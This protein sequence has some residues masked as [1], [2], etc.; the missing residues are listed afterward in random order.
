MDKKAM[1]K[2][3]YGLYLVTTYANGIDN[4]CIVNSVTQVTSDPQRIQV[5]L[6]KTDLTC[7]LIKQSKKLNLSIFDETVPFEYFQLFGM[8]S[9]KTENKFAMFK[10]VERSKNGI[11]Y[12]TLHTNALICANVIQQLDLDT[13]IM[14]IC[15]VEDMMVL[16]SNPSV[17]YA[18][19]QQNIKPVTKINTTNSEK[20]VCSICGYVYDNAVE[21]IPFEELP[22]TWVCPLCNHPKSV[23][24][25]AGNGK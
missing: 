15:E 23:F 25:K 5:T 10:D 14:F 4:G 16:N 11:Y 3:G 7:D 6:Q 19:Y 8:K 18:Y 9:G 20:W 2:I 24:E 22:E 13:H 17:T 21:K 1:Y 12:T